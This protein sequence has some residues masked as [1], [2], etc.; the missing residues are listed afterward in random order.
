MIHVLEELYGNVNGTVGNEDGN[1][2]QIVSENRS[3]RRM[4]HEEY[5]ILEEDFEFY[6]PCLDPIELSS[7]MIP[8]VEEG[9]SH[10]RD[11]RSDITDCGVWRLV[12]TTEASEHHELILG[13]GYTIRTSF[14][15]AN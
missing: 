9:D 8:H 6:A 4:T 7:K 1:D 10:S 5:Q 13:N 11:S 14:L 12:G 2:E 15:H 3:G